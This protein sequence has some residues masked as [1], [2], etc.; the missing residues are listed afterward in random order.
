MS[1]MCTS[2]DICGSL[3]PA[4]RIRQVNESLDIGAV[5]ARC[6]R[7][8]LRWR[9]R[10]VDTGRCR[11]GAP[12]ASCRRG[13]Q[14]RSRPTD[15]C[16][17]PPP[18]GAPRDSRMTSSIG[19]FPVTQSICLSV[20]AGR[21]QWRPDG[22]TAANW[23]AGQVKQRHDDELLQWHSKALDANQASH[24]GVI[25]RS[26]VSNRCQRNSVRKRIRFP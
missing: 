12:R 19:Q 11:Q 4:I 13:A 18:E 2:T 9:W 16:V 23:Q 1:R 5:I 7:R 26:T 14:S 25:E 21:R 22:R 17:F 10:N 6:R 20:D 24:L 3:V 15:C 8:R